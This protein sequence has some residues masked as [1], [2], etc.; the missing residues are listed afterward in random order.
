MSSVEKFMGSVRRSIEGIFKGEEHGHYEYEVFAISRKPGTAGIVA[1][2][3]RLEVGAVA[4]R[5]LLQK[6]SQA[7]SLARVTRVGLS[8]NCAVGEDGVSEY[9]YRN[10]RFE[11]ECS[12]PEGEQGDVFVEFFVN[13]IEA[14]AKAERSSDFVCYAFELDEH[15]FPYECEFS[16]YPGESVDSAGVVD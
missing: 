3:G 2:D 15:E 1:P 8:P 10:L 16:G 11:I 9:R 6:I 12:V 13:G 7:P 14:V 5:A 4:L